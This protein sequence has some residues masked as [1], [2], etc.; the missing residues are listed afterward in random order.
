MHSTANRT[1]AKLIRLT[2]EEAA[3]LKRKARAAGLNQ[4]TLIRMLL[5]GYRP[6]EKP[7]D[8]FYAVMRELRAIGNNINQLAGKANSQGW[9][10]AP[11]LEAE[12]QRWSSF[13]LDIER[14]FL[15]PERDERWR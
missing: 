6:K 14:Q 10:D 12:R 13:I 2:P 1:V 11:M 5:K 4:S 15:H 3:D 9:V 7:D 8:R